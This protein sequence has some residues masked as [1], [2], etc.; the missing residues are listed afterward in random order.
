MR[1][2]FR[3]TQGSVVGRHHVG[4]GNLLTGSNNQDSIKVHQ[5]KDALVGVICDG[6]SSGKYSEVGSRLGTQIFLT[7]LI[8]AVSAGRFDGLEAS[9]IALVL[10]GIRLAALTRL[11][12][13]VG[14]AV[15]RGASKA[16]Y[17]S[18]VLEN[19]LFT[20]M[21]ALVTPVF[22]VVATIGDGLYAL[23]GDVHRIGPFPDNAP[24]YLAYALLEA[25]SH[26]ISPQL[27]E[28]TVEEVKPT[29]EVTTLLIASDGAVELSEQA[30]R[31]IPGK[32]KLV[33][34]LSELWSSDD[35]FPD[36][37]THELLTLWLRQVNSEVVR[38]E[39]G[40]DG[41][42]ILNRY[43]G[44]LSDDTT[45]LVIRRWERKNA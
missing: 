25:D 11:D 1:G 34:A 14:Q 39:G 43:K 27:L 26:K 44:L 38:L 9:G 10:E 8:D 4:S 15:G 33:G 3:F 42:K 18:F 20:T 17:R 19:L 2:R 16:E 13:I 28:F 24:P 35:L 21:V 29:S 30:E 7:E 22:T 45:I 32:T 37:D 40:P 23:N 31:A 12:A 41:E 5:S 36:D 6:C